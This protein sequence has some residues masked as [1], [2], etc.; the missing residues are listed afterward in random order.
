MNTAVRTGKWRFWLRF[1]HSWEARAG[2]SGIF[3]Q[4]LELDFSHF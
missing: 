1:K 2:L 4:F 3:R